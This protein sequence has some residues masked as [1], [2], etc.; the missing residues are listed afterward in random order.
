MKEKITQKKKQIVVVDI[1]SVHLI[2]RS[3]ALFLIIYH[4][5]TPI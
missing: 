1:F 2:P 3:W 4:G 5:L